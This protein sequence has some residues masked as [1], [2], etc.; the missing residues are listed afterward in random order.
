MDA[1]A[2]ITCS[3]RIF[4]VS[5]YRKISLGTLRC[6]KKFVAAESSYGRQKGISHFLSKTFPITVSKNSFGNPSMLQKTSG[7][8]TSLW[9][10]GGQHVFPSK[11][12]CFTLPKVSL[13]TLCCFR[14]FPAEKTFYGRE[15]RYHVFPSKFTC[16]TFPKTFIG[17]SSV[18]E[19]KSGSGEFVWMREGKITQFRRNFLYHSTE[20]IH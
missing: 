15:W 5:D 4:L 14:K 11:F 12:L 2:D 16:L 13:G 9:M 1:R 10:R 20:Q 3:R 17:N 7:S 8:E 18:L 19:G 6:F